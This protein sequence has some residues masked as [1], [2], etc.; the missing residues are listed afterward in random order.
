MVFQFRGKIANF[1]CF[2]TND[3][4]NTNPGAAKYLMCSGEKVVEGKVIKE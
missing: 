1:E 2:S 3:M 4:E